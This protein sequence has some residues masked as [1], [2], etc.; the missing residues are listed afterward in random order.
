MIENITKIRKSAR[1]FFLMKK[2]L[3]GGTGLKILSAESKILSAGC[4]PSSRI[5]SYAL[6]KDGFQCL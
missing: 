1:A 5:P 4:H 2:F 3:E 6:D